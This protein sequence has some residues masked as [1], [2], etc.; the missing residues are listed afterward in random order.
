MAELVQH[1]DFFIARIPPLH[2]M[3][4]FFEQADNI[5]V[6]SKFASGVAFVFEMVLGG[7]VAS[8]H[9]RLLN[10][11]KAIVLYTGEVKKLNFWQ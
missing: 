11:E 6:L 5:G 7:L 10:R 8:Q 4:A 3:L 2:S 1:V 9:S